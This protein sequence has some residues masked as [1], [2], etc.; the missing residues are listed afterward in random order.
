[1]LFGALF[2]IV[3]KN[4]KLKQSLVIFILVALL[5]TVADQVA[6]G[7]CKPLFQ[8]F[9][10]THD[11]IVG[12]MIDIVNGYRGGKYGFFSSHASNTFAG[13][14]FFALLFRNTRVSVLL[15]I[16]A[17][18]CTYSR[19]YLGVHYPTDILTGLTFGILS[20][21]VFHFLYAY[22]GKRYFCQTSLNTTSSYAKQDFLVFYAAFALSCIYILIRALWYA[23]SF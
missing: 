7:I 3:I 19:L 8:R 12:P 16:W 23:D 2:Y 20:G 15:F 22:V 17:T 13:A 21:Y 14:T 5:I 6:S 10:P 18:L 4:N 11:P 1:M 9:R